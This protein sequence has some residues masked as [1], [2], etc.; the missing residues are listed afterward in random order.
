MDPHLGM[1]RKNIM[2]CEKVVKK[3]GAGYDGWTENGKMGRAM[4]GCVEGK[5]GSKEKSALH[6]CSR[7]RKQRVEG[8]PG[9]AKKL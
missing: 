4:T 8:C 1:C 5:E 3:I 7:C 6:A 2:W 9:S